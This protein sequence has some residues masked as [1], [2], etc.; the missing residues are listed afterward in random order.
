MKHKSRLLIIAILFLLSAQSTPLF[1][2]NLSLPGDGK[3]FWVGYMYPSYNKVG[4][5]T[6]AGFYGAYLLISTY[7]NNNVTVNYFDHTSGAELLVGQ[8]YIPA[9]TGIQVPIN[10]AQVIMPDAG[11]V[12]LYTAIHV[13]ALRAINV[14]YFS[15]GA[16]SGGSFLPITTAG[17]GTKYVIASYNNNPG[18]LGLLG[19]F[20]GPS[21]IEVSEGFFEIIAPFN[22]T[23]VTITT[24]ST[25]M[26]GHAGFHSGKNPT[27]PNEK[28]ASYTVNLQRG[29]CYLVKSA[30]DDDG[31]DISGSVVESSLPVA[32]IAGHENAAIGGVS[33]RA[34][35]GRD[36]M[37]EQM[38]PVNMWDTTGYVMIPT[39][40][41]YPPNPDL[42]EGVGQNYRTF[43]Y[44][45]GV[46]INMYSG[47]VSGPIA[48]N[49]TRLAQPPP[50]R[51]QEVY[52]V[53]FEG[54]N[55]KPF[56]VMMYENRNFATAAPYPAPSMITVIPMS[57]WRTSF[58]WYVP[59]NKFETLQ[60]YYV[61]IIGQTTDFSPAGGI[62]GSYNGGS[63]I[64]ISQ[65][66]SLDQRFKGTI[67]NYPNLTGIRFKL[68][69]G[70]YYATGP[71]PFMV[72]NYGYRA[73]DPNFDL[74][75]FDGDDYFFAYGLPV[76][77]K[78]GGSPHMHVTIDSTCSSWNICVHD[79]TLGLTNQGI[80]SVTL[81]DD[82]TGDQFDVHPGK[83]FYNTRLGDS[84]DPDN[85]N[86]INFTGEDSDVCFSVDVINVI[87]SAYAPLFIVD[88]QGGAT[89]V[90]LH[91][92][93]PLVQ[94]APDSGKY[95][96]M[97]LHDP[98]K[99]DSCQSYVFKNIAKHDPKDTGYTKNNFSLNSAALKLNNPNFKIT[100][101]VPPLP[102]TLRAGDSAIITVC[103]TPTDTTT[104]K[105]TLLLSTNCKPAPV[106]LIGNAG[107]P[108]IWASNHDFGGV[109]VD[110]TKCDTVGVYNIG[111]FPFTLTT[112]W[113]LQNM[114]VN[115]TFATVGTAPA[116][117]S[118]DLPITLKP[119]Q[120]VLLDFCYTP[121]KE[122]HDSTVQN[123]GTT[124]QDPYKHSNKDSSILYG[125]GV[126]TGFI[127]DRSQQAYTVTCDDSEIVRMYLL[128]NATPGPF[129]PAAL[130][131]SVYITGPN[132]NEFYI[133]RNQKGFTP[134]R[135]FNLNPAESIWVDVV[136]K[137]NLAQP[138][139]A[140]YAQRIAEIVATG[141]GEK[142]KIINFTGDV[143]HADPVVAPNIINYGQVPLG[144]TTTNSF[145]VT[146][147]GSANLIIHS[148]YPLTDPIVNI[149]GLAPG[150]T[151][152]PGELTHRAQI[153]MALTTYKDT[154]VQL[155]VT[156]ETSCAAQDT[157]TL[158]IAASLVQPT[159]T[160]HNYDSVFLNCR[161]SLDHIT[162]FNKGSTDLTLRKIDIVDQNPA[163][164]PQFS[165]TNGK[166]ELVVD[167]VIHPAKNTNLGPTFNIL[168]SPTMQGVVT[169]SVIVTWDSLDVNGKVA[170]TFYS[171]N[172]LIGYG[173]LEHETF[174]PLQATYANITANYVD[175][176]ITMKDTLPANVLA[177]GVTFSVTY[178]R[179]LLNY[180]S[181]GGKTYPAYNGQIAPYLGADAVPVNNGDGTETITYTLQSS[182]AG[183]P[184]T[185][186]NPSILTM[187]FQVMVALDKT[188]PITISNAVFW[189]SS[190]TDT[191]CYVINDYIPA[192]FTPDPSCGDSTLR[193]WL[194][195]IQPTRIVSLTPNPAIEGSS[196]IL[197]YDVN[198]DNTPVTIELYNALGE[199]IRTVGKNVIQKKGEYNFPFGVKNMTSGLYILR[200]IT[201]SSEESSEFVIQK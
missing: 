192:V 29:Q 41:S 168:Y 23:Q 56:S 143:L 193:G 162:A 40:D 1:S 95:L 54:T 69:P 103:F 201:P 6:T 164:P 102:T 139:P 200:I 60:A 128:N 5:A 4:N 13:T 11:D 161:N 2:Q 17:L 191:L 118:N 65:V 195:K 19:G 39:K 141:P 79:S 55:G 144:V 115:F 172:V 22:N 34:L 126:T 94:I 86:E 45:N 186:L 70:S 155:I 28:A 148:I 121:H 8:Y 106:Q 174:S 47:G 133:L 123:W 101:T 25:T 52:P 98:T 73:L 112:Q 72:Y 57:R 151:I 163:G 12:A 90:E 111:K 198:I 173:K 43:S 24:N 176:P 62:M 159:N 153:D 120:K 67:P 125:S 117:G 158:C 31:D 35:E 96:L 142:D 30:S 138:L 147:T 196:P 179:D 165:F 183:V 78:L 7:T 150:D 61:N 89:L 82:P 154:C 104:Q 190:P 113:V 157:I 184:I 32:V 131:D 100:G 145:L 66:L 108:I 137:P 36:F 171:S 109:L 124:L 64:P 135:N 119:G 134:L 38:Y 97:P 20:L 136:F 27:F 156:Y 3:D 15:T 175:V 167:S 53:D 48:M 182:N 166:Q 74:G 33:N 81:M 169:D 91:Y 84:L 152:K 51:F 88:D 10:I 9:R 178:K 76:G 59:A 149:K 75:D 130:V 187:H 68:Q 110:S 87:D 58:L 146:D 71:H 160:G 42:Y 105:D 107:I 140:K 46:N 63:I 132:A 197:T 170:K 185:F 80:K 116:L 181:D 85:T 49:T 77:M 16:C 26:G 189:G 129:V 127:W 199:H 188:T 37:V 180:V 99:P 194:G 114:G 122:E 50:E 21:S 93:P 44:N 18:N 83:Q 14:E 92:K 177:N